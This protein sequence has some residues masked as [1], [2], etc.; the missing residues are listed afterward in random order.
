MQRKAVVVI[1][2]SPDALEEK[3]L[4]LLERNVEVLESPAVKMDIEMRQ[5]SKLLDA[6]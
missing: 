4:A 3:E 2:A 6:A 1:P 5:V